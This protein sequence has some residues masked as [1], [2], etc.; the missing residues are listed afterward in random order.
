MQK[1]ITNLLVL[2]LCGITLV[3]Q[4]KFPTDYEPSEA[5]PYGQLN[6]EAPP[7]AADFDPMIG[8]CICQS[9]S[10]NPDGTW[11]DTLSMLWKF[12]YIMN[13]T[14]VQDEVWREN[15]LYAGSIRQ[16]HPDSARW[17]V[18]YFSNPGV[19]TSPG[20]WQ[21]NLEG[22]EI[23]LYKEQQAPNGMDGASRLTFY[24]MS[25]EGFSWKGEWVDASG[26]IVYPFWQIFCRRQ[27]E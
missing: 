20:V 15:G 16:Y 3:A 27:K 1:R 6:P 18:T 5:H 26:T 2:L 23:I 7:Q 19:S 24:D 21:G 8:T 13:G 9:V 4:T 12:K 22:D 10:R 25:D 14:A 11:Q 17:V